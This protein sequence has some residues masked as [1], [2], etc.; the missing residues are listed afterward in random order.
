MKNHFSHYQVATIQWRTQTERQELIL[1]CLDVPLP[2]EPK[3]VTAKVKKKRGPK[4]KV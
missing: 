1:T 3:K 2:V 4:P